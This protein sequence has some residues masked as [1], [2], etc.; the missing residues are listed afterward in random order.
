[1]VCHDQKLHRCKTILHVPRFEM[2]DDPRMDPMLLDKK[3]SA[4]QPSLGAFRDT[5]DKNGTALVYCPTGP[6]SLAH[7]QTSLSLFGF[8]FSRL[9]IEVGAR[10]TFQ[11]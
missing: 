7:G 9:W 3:E 6:E 5:K 8:R 2:H 1:M 4:G 10:D 11:R